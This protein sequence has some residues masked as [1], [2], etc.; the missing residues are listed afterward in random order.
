MAQQI[1]MIHTD[2][3]IPKSFRSDENTDEGR[4]AIERLRDNIKVQGI[5]TPL[6][7]CEKNGK[8]IIAAGNRRYFAGKMAKVKIFPCIVFPLNNFD[9]IRIQ[10]N[11]MRED[12]KPSQAAQY[13]KLMMKETNKTLKELSKITGIPYDT[14]RKQSYIASII[15]GFQDLIDN[16]RMSIRAGS[17]ISALTQK[18]QLKL[19]NMILSSGFKKIP[20]TVIRAFTDDF[21]K[22][23]FVHEKRKRVQSG[24]ES[25]GAKVAKKK[26]HDSLSTNEN[27]LHRLKERGNQIM[28][29]L[30]PLLSSFQRAM[31]INEVK[32]H[33]KKEHTALYNDVMNVLNASHLKIN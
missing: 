9:R 1:Q 24:Y 33:F 7:V 5:Q 26:L 27:D 19:F 16:G 28:E 30:E 2:F 23:L 6:S 13:V 32:D 22:E 14:L 21:D 4:R 8:Y 18:G 25:T 20:R 12:L 15:K 31:N 10:E 3:L 11:V 29:N 17:F